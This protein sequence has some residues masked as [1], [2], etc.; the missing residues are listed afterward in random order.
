M[1]K[2]ATATPW[3]LTLYGKSLKKRETVQAVLRF[4]PDVSGKR[5][6]EIGCATGVTSYLLRQRGGEWSSVDFEKDHVNS[7]LRLVGD[8]VFLIGEDSLPFDDGRFD[9]VVGINF[10]EHI[11][12]DDRFISEMARVLKPGGELV[13]TSP[14]GETNRLGYLFKRAYGFTAA[15]KGFGHARDGYTPPVLRAKFA[16]AG[17]QIERVDTYSRFFAEVV[18]DTLNFAYHKQAKNGGGAESPAD[19]FHGTTSPMS[20]EAF[21]KVGLSFRLYSLAFP[22]IRAVTMLDRLIPSSPGY[23]LV[24]RAVKAT[25]D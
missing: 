1:A 7:A 23:M 15:S 3:Q 8:N 16:R 12:D 19:D 4:L 17:L 13:F 18:E 24:A 21:R 11:E 22:A 14:T 25:A 20:G 6:L 10:L 2:S 9:V 5:C